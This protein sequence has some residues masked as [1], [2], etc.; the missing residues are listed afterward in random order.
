LIVTAD[1]S[2]HLPELF[3]RA[4]VTY[5]ASPRAIT[6]M[7]Y[8][9]ADDGRTVPYQAAPGQPMYDCVR[10]AETIQKVQEYTR[11]A[12]T[13]PGAAPLVLVDGLRTRTACTPDALLPPADEVEV[14]GTIRP[15]D[16]LAAEL[17]PVHGIDPPR[18]TRQAP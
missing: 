3:L 9:S 8:V 10:R 2:A 17:T 13:L 12:E 7:A 15:W 4:E 16:D 1:G 11:Q 6:P 18:W 5:L 14:D